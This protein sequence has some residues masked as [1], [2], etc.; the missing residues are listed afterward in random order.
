MLDQLRLIVLGSKDGFAQYA[1]LI[2]KAIFLQVLCLLLKKTFA[3]NF[4]HFVKTVDV[5][6][7]STL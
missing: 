3:E 6:P 7:I 4:P 2:A 5:Q 1:S